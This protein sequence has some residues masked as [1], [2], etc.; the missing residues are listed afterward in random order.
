[1]NINLTHNFV[2]RLTQHGG[3]LFLLAVSL[4]ALSCSK[5]APVTPETPVMPPVVT[6]ETPADI[7]ATYGAGNL[8]RWTTWKTATDS[9]FDFLM[10]GDSYTQGNYYT[11]RLRVKLLTAG[12]ADGGP[13]YCS[14]GRYDP[15][16][17]YSIDGSMDE[18]EL[19]FT[20]DPLKWAAQRENTYGPCGYVKNTA[21][22]ATI[23]VQGKVNLNTLTI[24]FEKHA[25]AG[26]FR[27][28]LNG[29]AWTTVSMTS[30]TQEIGS[31]DVDVTGLAMSSLDIEPLAA[32]EIFCGVHSKRSVNALAMDKVGAAGAT[33]HD[34][35]QNDLWKTST[36]IINPELAT[37]MFGTNE[38]M[39]NVSPADMK[40]D[41]QNIINKLR[42]I[43]PNCDILIMAP[44]ETMYEKEHPQKYKTADYGNALYQVA[45]ANNTAF[46]NYAKVF[47]PFSQA[48]VTG[49]IIDTDRTHPGQV[50]SQ[51]IS[52]AMYNMLTK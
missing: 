37:I 24:I 6:P 29:G 46:I 26:N 17:L 16:G 36:Q 51:M 25:N 32:G 21:A 20:Y 15:T 30:P 48:Q 5:N 41:V 40:V 22:N 2:K 8:K 43:T 19:S 52:D 50:G 11:W 13:G 33:A 35:A 42:E 1:M 39:Q 10:L 14:F 27:Y 47:G 34:F 49:G 23:N 3:R 45:V 44:P 4:V 9:R 7:P 38:I 18:D 31:V 12:F 28:R